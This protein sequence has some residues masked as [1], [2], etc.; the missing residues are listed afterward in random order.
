[1]PVVRDRFVGVRTIQRPI[2]VTTPFGYVS[3]YIAPAPIYAPQVYS[4]PIYAPP[5]YAAP[6]A[7]A[8]SET[9]A[10]LTYQVRRLTEEVEQLRR[11]QALREQPQ[12]AAPPPPEQAPAPLTVLVFRDGHRIEV[13]S[14][15]I[16]GQTLWLVDEQNATMIPLSD[17]DLDATRRENRERGV[18]F[19]R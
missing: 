8:V 5:I 11:E 18:R 6:Q 3:P 2:V 15:V 13:E 9:E 17:L 19:L 12:T 1:V 10:E 16:T 4:E 7:P 14:Y